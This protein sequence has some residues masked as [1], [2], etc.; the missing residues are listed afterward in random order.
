MIVKLVGL[1]DAE[2]DVGEIVIQ[3]VDGDVLKINGVDAVIERL[4]VKVF[5]DASKLTKLG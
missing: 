5:S 4:E 2:A 3:G 1:A